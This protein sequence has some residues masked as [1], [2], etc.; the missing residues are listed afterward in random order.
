MNTISQIVGSLDAIPLTDGQAV[1]LTRLLEEAYSLGR[2]DGY[3]DGFTV[4]A[5]WP[6]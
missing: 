1:L 6:R 5:A 2:V 4:G 3:G